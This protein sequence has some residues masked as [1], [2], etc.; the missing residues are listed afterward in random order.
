FSR[1]C[2]D[3]ICHFQRS[4]FHPNR[5]IVTAGELLTFPRPEWFERV[6]RDHE[7]NSVIQFG[8][9]AAEMA[10]PSVTMHKIGIDVGGV[11]I[12]AAAERAKNRLQWLR[13]SEAARVEF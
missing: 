4:F 12:D 6:R 10:V 5:E 2:D 1:N 7:R 11:E 8:D 3:R 9:N 13:T